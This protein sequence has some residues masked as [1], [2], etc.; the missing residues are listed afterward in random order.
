M[1]LV[2]IVSTGLS[3]ISPTPSPT[4]PKKDGE[5][6]MVREEIFRQKEQQGINRK[7][8]RKAARRIVRQLKYEKFQQ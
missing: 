3:A 4:K 5:L 2:C 6:K 7:Q 8:A 1:F